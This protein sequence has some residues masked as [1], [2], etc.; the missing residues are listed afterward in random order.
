M[1]K[2]FPAM[3]RTPTSSTPGTIEPRQPPRRPGDDDEPDDEERLGRAQDGQRAEHE[4]RRDLRDEHVEQAQGATRDERE[5]QAAAAGRLAPD[6]RDEHDSDQRQPDPDEDFG[7]GQPLEH[8]PDRHRDDGREHAGHGRHNAHPPGCEPRV[9]R[10]DAD[11]PGHP[12]R[13]GPAD[14]DD[15]G[16]RLAAHEE[17]D[18]C[19]HHAGRLG[20][21]DDPGH[22]AAATRNATAEVP[23]APC[24]R[25]QETEEDD[26]RPDRREALVQ[27]R[28]PS[29]RA[30]TGSVPSSSG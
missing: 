4:S 8:D 5:A 15:A 22:R 9:Q 23:R 26:R 14:V 13:H 11:H 6:T 27:A 30:A 10:A 24:E 1:K 18:R 3:S 25:G 2:A 7:P 17:E 20:E 28:A 12:G 29:A 19:D 16:E 21:Q